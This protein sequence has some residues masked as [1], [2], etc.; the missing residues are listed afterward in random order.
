MSN[1]R[2]SAAVVVLSKTFHGLVG[3]QVEPDGHVDVLEVGRALGA[4]RRAELLAVVA[5]K[6]SGNSKPRST[7]IRERGSSGP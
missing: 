4:E 1:H 5:A 3:R 2:P 6:S 7:S